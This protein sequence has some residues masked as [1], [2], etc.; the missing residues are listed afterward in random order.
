MPSRKL[1]VGGFAVT[2]DIPE[3]V[4]KR[5]R[6]AVSR[7]KPGIMDTADS[8]SAPVY[9]DALPTLRVT[10]RD[11]ARSLDFFRPDPNL[12]DTRTALY[13]SYVVPVAE[14]SDLAAEVA[15][16]GWY[17]TIELPGGIVT[18]GQFDHRPLVA[19]YGFPE[20][21]KNMT[22]LDVATFDGFWAFEME[23]R[24][25]QVTAIDIARASDVDLP[26]RALEQL[27][28][29]GIDAPVGTG[30]AI[31]S[32]ELRSKVKRVVSSVYDL[33]P[34]EM[35]TFDFVHLG[36]LLL[37][38]KSPIT[39]LQRVRS[40]TGHQA[41]I[42]DTYSPDL[43]RAGGTT[44]VEYLGGWEGV[45]WWIPSLDTL[46]QMVLDAGYSDVKL[47]NAY[48]MGRLKEHGGLWRAALL[49]TV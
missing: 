46:A 18:P 8:S 37:H 7:V 17:H 22:A 15:R 16:S 48:H 35:G 39:A 9:A 28:A 23:R 24:G 43:N 44:V 47:L 11:P 12:I 25:A 34:D 30:F 38:L 19:R 4:A 6:Q 42:V 5:V 1:E 33:N 32:R 41:L 2:V 14:K 29:E 21:M 36:D 13:P 45:V 26:P 10:R 20:T 3:G 40:V 27:A 49:A 31:A